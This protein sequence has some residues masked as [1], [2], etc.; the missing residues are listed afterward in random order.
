MKKQ[1]NTKHG[2]IQKELGEGQF[3]FVFNVRPGKENEAELLRNY[4]GK[5]QKQNPSS[6]SSSSLSSID[7][8]DI[9]DDSEDDEAFLAKYDDDGNFIG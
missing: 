3:G 7:R 1:K 2:Q 5:N 8:E 9:S 6:S 4:W